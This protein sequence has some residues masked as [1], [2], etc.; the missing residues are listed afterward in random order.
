MTIHVERPMYLNIRPHHRR[1]ARDLACFVEE[2]LEGDE[3]SDLI[4]S[5]FRALFFS[6]FIANTLFSADPRTMAMPVY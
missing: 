6:I 5:S 1:D 3:L 2:H 4:P